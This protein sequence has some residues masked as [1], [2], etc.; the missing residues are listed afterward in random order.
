MY[1]GKEIEGYHTRK[2]LYKCFFLK[3]YSSNLGNTFLGFINGFFCEAAVTVEKEE[4]ASFYTA[5]FYDDNE[6]SDDKRAYVL[7][8]SPTSYSAREE[9]FKLYVR[10]DLLV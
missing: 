7:T 5:L 3:I 2:R 1:P 10:A 9:A 4:L 6:I 8:E